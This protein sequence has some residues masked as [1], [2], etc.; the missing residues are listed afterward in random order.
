[1]NPQE[2]LR[3]PEGATHLRYVAGLSAVDFVEGSYGFIKAESAELDLTTDVIPEIILNLSLPSASTLPMFLLLG[4]EYFQEMNGRFYGL[5]NG[6]FN[7][8]SLI[9]VNVAS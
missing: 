1:M 3:M 5:R 7:T 2:S 4:T 6:A 8:L 9:D